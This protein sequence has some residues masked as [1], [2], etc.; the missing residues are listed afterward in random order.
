M[1][2]ATDAGSWRARHARRASRWS[3]CDHLGQLLYPPFWAVKK[4]NRLFRGHLDGV[5]LME[6]VEHDIAATGN[7]RLGALACR[8]ERRLVSRG[9]SL[10]VGIRE[11]VVLRKPLV[12]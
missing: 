2:V 6:Q 1:S 12:P 4:R 7:S 10:P 5:A 8:L 11:A 3:P 9:I